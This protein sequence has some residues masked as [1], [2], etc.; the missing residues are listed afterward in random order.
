LSLT[1][2]N[3]P[4]VVVSATASPPLVSGLPAASRRATV[5]VEVLVPSAG[6]E[7]GE[8]V[9]WDVAP[10]AG[11]GVIANEALV[12]PVSPVDAAISV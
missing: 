2:L 1:A 4:A 3:V 12:A 5:I 7:V 9:I 8:A 6:I 10:E 11:P